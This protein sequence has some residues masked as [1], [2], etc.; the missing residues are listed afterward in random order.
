[1]AGSEQDPFPRLLRGLLRPLV[2]TL[3]AR[4]LTAPDFYRMLKRIYVD[5]AHEDFRIG[6]APPTDSRISLLT[7]VH[8]RDVRTFL[9]EG[10]AGWEETRRREAA[11]ATVLGQWLARPEYTGP[12]GTPRALPKSGAEGADFESLV[13]SV[14][15]DIRPRTVLD[16]LMRQGLVAEGEDGRLS[17]VAEAV[18]GPGGEESKLVFFAANVGDHLAAASENLLSDSPPFYERAVFY[19]RLTEGALDIVEATARD[20]AQTL[21]E[22]INRAGAE[23]QARDR[24][25]PDNGS[26]FRLGVYFY[27]TDGSGDARGRGDADADDPKAR[28]GSAD[29]GET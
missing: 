9:E 22:D 11:F 17:V 25:A 15:T 21:L 20:K 16:E 10:D 12:D 2:R 29:D 14:S 13:R 7:G 23:A 1:M 6:D 3:I 8:R 4:G 18:A 19:T 28:P 24:A 26:R 5:V 27:R